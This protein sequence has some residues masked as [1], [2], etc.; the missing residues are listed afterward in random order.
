MACYIGDVD[1]TIFVGDG[2]LGSRRSKLARNRAL[3]RLGVVLATA[4]DS[5]GDG[6]IQGKILN[7]ARIVLE[8]KLGVMVSEF[9]PAKELFTTYKTLI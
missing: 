4:G 1:Q 2:D 3:L 9:G 6:E 7:V 5:V 8:L